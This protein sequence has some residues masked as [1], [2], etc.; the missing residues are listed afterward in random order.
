MLFVGSTAGG[1]STRSC[2]PFTGTSPPVPNAPSRS[3]VPSNTDGTSGS[4]NNTASSPLQPHVMLSSSL[5][6]PHTMDWT[7]PL[8]PQTMLSQSA[9]R[10]AVPHTMLSAS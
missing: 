10:Q 2:V 6:L 5:E 8:V 9:S 1:G 4:S 3:T 7:S